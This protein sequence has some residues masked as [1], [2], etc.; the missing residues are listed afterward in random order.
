LLGIPEILNYE[1]VP[2]AAHVQVQD[3]LDKKVKRKKISRLEA[4]QYM[5]NLIP[6]LDYSSKFLEV[7][8]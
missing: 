7:H 3:G 2:I 6:A 1:R 4:E 5:S 8:T